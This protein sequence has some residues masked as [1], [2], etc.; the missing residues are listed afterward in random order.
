[1]KPCPNCTKGTIID[2]NSMPW[3]CATCRGTGRVEDPERV[4]PGWDDDEQETAA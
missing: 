2:Q 1:M 3:R 4:E